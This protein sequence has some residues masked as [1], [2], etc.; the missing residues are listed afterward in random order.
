M[1]I[2]YSSQRREMLLFLTT[3]MAAVT[4]CANQQY[5]QLEQKFDV[6]VNAEQKNQPFLLED[7]ARSVGSVLTYLVFQGILFHVSRNKTLLGSQ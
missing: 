5:A 7:W 1:K 3:T 6:S 2:G 4:S